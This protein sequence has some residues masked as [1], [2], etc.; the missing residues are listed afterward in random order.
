[1]EKT[2]IL[3]DKQIAQRICRIAYEIYEA[4]VDEKQVILAGIVGNGYI[5]TQMLAEQLET[6]SP[7]RVI[8]CEVSINKKEP[9]EEIT[10]SIPVSEYKNQ[11]LVLI[12]DVLHTGTTLIYGVKHFLDV[13][14]KQF[15]TVVLVDRNHKR[16][17][18]KADY[19]GISLSTSLNENV[20]VKFSEG[21]ALALLE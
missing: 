18:I 19:K 20:A 9:R 17:P 10:T 11:S 7:L 4:N 12:D 15:K 13:P 3:N 8:L 21:K 5:L 6:I 1:M 14:L 2:I 16:Y